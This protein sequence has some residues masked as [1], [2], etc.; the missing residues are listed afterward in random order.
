MSAAADVVQV[1]D[2]THHETAVPFWGADGNRPCPLSTERWQGQPGTPWRTLCRAHA[3]VRTLLL[4]CCHWDL[5]SSWSRWGL[6]K[7]AA[8]HRLLAFFRTWGQTGPTFQPCMWAWP[9]W[10]CSRALNHS[11][12]DD[13]TAALPEGSLLSQ[14]GFLIG[15]ET[16]S[17]TH[18]TSR[19][20]ASFGGSWMGPRALKYHTDVIPC[21]E[22]P[23]S[24]R[25]RNNNHADKNWEHQFIFFFLQ[26]E[27]RH[28]IKDSFLLSIFKS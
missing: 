27:M 16:V 6:E 18:G 1:I 22:T 15:P 12:S 20:T 24:Y 23:C 26:G 5:L 7:R 10:P 4:S 17:S 21:W 25:G 9:G 2:S 13:H 11:L 3:R 19:P 8:L 28:S 14:S